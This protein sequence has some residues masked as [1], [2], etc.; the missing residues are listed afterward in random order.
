VSVFDLELVKFRAEVRGWSVT[1]WPDED[2]EGVWFEVAAPHVFGGAVFSRKGVV[3]TSWNGEALVPPLTAPR[4]TI[5]RLFV[6]PPEGWA[7]RP[8]WPTG[9]Q[10]VDLGWMTWGK[11]LRPGQNEVGMTV[12][13][14]QSRVVPY[15]VV[16]APLVSLDD[17]RQFAERHKAVAE[18]TY[19]LAEIQTFAEVTP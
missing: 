1:E 8:A 12:A 11:E 14:V 15:R 16:I 7:Y 2:P 13:I 18:M 3:S 4:W 19:I 10:R 9:P 17:F 6:E 5:E